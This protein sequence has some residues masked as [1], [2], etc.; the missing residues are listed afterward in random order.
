MKRVLHETSRLIRDSFN[1]EVPV[2]A[3]QQCLET[4]KV[5]YINKKKFESKE[6]SFDKLLET[7][8]RAVCN[9]AILQMADSLD[10]GAYDYLIVTGG[11]GEAWYG[12]I[13]DILKGYA[14]TLEIIPG[15]RNDDLS[16]IYANVR[17]YYL[18]RYNK[19]KRGQ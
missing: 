18:Y 19:L 15:N 7:A 11:T 6:Y 10:I 17:G 4:G 14:D 9:E 12:Q 5:R 1:V 8:S 2:P 13:K 16:F 3:M